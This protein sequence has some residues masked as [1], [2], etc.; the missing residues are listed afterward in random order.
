METTEKSFRIYPIYLDATLSIKKG[1]KYSIQNTIAKPTFKEI[2]QSLDLLKIK[3]EAQ[4]DKMHPKT[5]SE[6]GQF[7]VNC[8]SSK[9]SIACMIVKKIQEIRANASLKIKGSGNILNLVPKSK[10]KGKKK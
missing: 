3:Y 10:K 9:Q 8:E 4:P 5:I 7:I 2:K 6:K 1:R